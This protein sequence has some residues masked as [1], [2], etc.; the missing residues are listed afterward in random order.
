MLFGCSEDLFDEQINNSKFKV[1]YVDSKGLKKNVELLKSLKKERLIDSNISGR[2]INDPIN[3][4]SIDTDFVKHLQGEN[5]D[6]YTFN[7]IEKEENYLDNLVLMSQNDGSYMPY[8]MRYSFTEQ[9][10]QALITGSPIDFTNKGKVLLLNDYNIVSSALGRLMYQEECNMTSTWEEVVTI[11]HDPNQCDCYG[12]DY[13]TYSHVLVGS[14][15]C[16]GGGGGSEL[17]DVATSPHGGGGTQTFPDTPCGRMQKKSNGT[18]FK[19]K[20]KDLNKSTNFNKRFETGYYEKADG[21]FNFMTGLDISKKRTLNFPLGLTSFMH[22]HMNNVQV[23]DE[24]GNPYTEYSTKMLSPADVGALISAA[25]NSIAGGLSPYDAYGVMLSS[26]GVFSIGLTDT[27]I[28]M[29]S[30]LKKLM[31][32]EYTDN[33]KEIFKNTSANSLQRK[34]D[35]QIMLLK[36]L[37]KNG[38]GDKVVLFEAEVITEPGQVLPTINWIKKTLNTDG[39]LIEEPC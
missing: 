14:M 15:T 11:S 7:I 18:A 12:P 3:N 39:M 26:E 34:K 10:K 29:S 21:S 30:T 6:S 4:F 8:V 5:F 24:D 38:F 9:D 22:I 27:D 35:L 32:K 2:I 1:N 17:D 23:E 33:V 16:D 37:K 19:E 28:A 36:L 31:D 13:V 20:F 25:G